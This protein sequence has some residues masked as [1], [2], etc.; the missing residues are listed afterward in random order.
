MR[1]NGVLSAVNWALYAIAL[2]LI[3]HILVKPAFLDLSWI[4]LIVFLPLLG[5]CYV[6]VHPDERRQVVVFTLGFLLLDRALTHVDVKSLVAV[7]IG[8]A[9]AIGVVALIAKWYGRLNWSA[10]GAL[11]LVAVL[12]N[13]SFHRDNLAALSHFTLKYE[14]ERLYNGAWVDY[15][16]V[17]LYDVDGDGKQEIITYGNAEEMPLPEEKPKKPE[18]EAERKALADKLLHLQAEPVS[19]YVLTWKD[20]KLVRMPNDQIAPET[21]AKIKEQ[22]PSDYPGFPYYTMKDG[23]LVPNVQRQS[24]AEAMLQV[25]TAPYRALLLDMQNIGDKLAENGGSMDTRSAMGEKYRDVSIKEGLL[26]GTYEGKPFAATTKATKL[27]GTMKL[28]DGRE[29]LITMGEHL[30]VMA[31][32]PDG[33]A[34]EA[35]S[36]TR[37][38]M[39]LATAEFIPADLDKDGADELLVA[40]SPSYILKAKPNGTWEILWASE[41]GDRSF[42][43]TNYAPVGSSGEPE[44]VAMAKSW[45]S[46][47][48][49]RYLAGYRYTPEGLEQTWRIYLPLLNVQV[50]DIDGDKENEIVATIYD[51]H[52]LIVFKQHNVPVV[53]LVILVFVGLI[54]YGIARRVR[55]A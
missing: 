10:V 40:N 19:L 50:G 32:E 36:L 41:E 37:K 24:Y 1:R 8:G 43:F 14:S 31:V 15:F 26:S 2:F 25:G 38:E 5:F 48:D 4:A 54:G 11:V 45:V 29:G 23:Q 51:K 34:V 3:Y 13:V 28:P 52:R 27:V 16:P 55:H 21:M 22:M 33:T 30:S 18:T 9:V 53:P 17:T 7:V 46:T 39:P 20:G 44:I 12:A 47:T 6:L 35:Y 49:T 42:R